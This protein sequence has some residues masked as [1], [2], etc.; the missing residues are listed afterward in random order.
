MTH[1]PLKSPWKFK[2]TNST[3][4]TTQKQEKTRGHYNLINSVRP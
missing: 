3:T 2:K 4:V 1:S